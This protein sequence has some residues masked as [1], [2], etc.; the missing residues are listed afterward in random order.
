MRAILAPNTG[1]QTPPGFKKVIM[2]AVESGPRENKEHLLVPLGTVS[3]KRLES[4]GQN[5]L[6]QRTCIYDFAKS[7]GDLN[8]SITSDSYKVIHDCYQLSP[9]SEVLERSTEQG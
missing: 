7:I 8:C 4:R 1:K 2:R 5:I 3:G 6:S 9:W